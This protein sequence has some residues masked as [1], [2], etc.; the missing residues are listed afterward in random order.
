M[1]WLVAWCML[2][3]GFVLGAMWAGSV[4]DGGEG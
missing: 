4:R 2:T 1:M 3:I